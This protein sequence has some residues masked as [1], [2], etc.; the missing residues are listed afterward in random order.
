MSFQKGS[1]LEQLQSY[2]LLNNNTT[3]ATVAAVNNKKALLAR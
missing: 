2:G 1:I 3:E